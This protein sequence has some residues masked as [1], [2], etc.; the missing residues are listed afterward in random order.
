MRILDRS[1]PRIPVSEPAATRV[2]KVIDLRRT[3]AGDAAGILSLYQRVARIPG[4]LA[5]LEHEVS[6]AYVDGFLA[7]TLDRGIGFVAESADG[8]AGEIH[9]Y[10]PGIYCFSHVLSDL[11]IA[12]DP[13]VQ[14]M[15][16]GRRLFERFM[17]AVA[18]Q[19]PDTLRVELIARES[20]QRAIRF[21]ESLGFHREG[22]FA[23]RIRNL[24]GSLESDIPMAWTREPG[25][26]ESRPGSRPER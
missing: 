11:T 18:E 7:S 19:R 17:S 4:G 25:P 6:R 13:A 10:S 20:N 21:Y 5:R 3:Q 24:D 12:V 9:A 8:V 14:G 22:T 26:A 16:V 1:L 15:G 23:G 2:T